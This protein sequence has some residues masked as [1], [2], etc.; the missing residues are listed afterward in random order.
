ML[1]SGYLLTS[2]A[3]NVEVYCRMTRSACLLNFYIESSLVL[4][5]MT[6]L[7]RLSQD[8]RQGLTSCF[9]VERQLP[10]NDRAFEDKLLDTEETDLP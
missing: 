2:S 8:D 5:A 7:A 4:A 10:A 9:S 1:S 6:F 3:L